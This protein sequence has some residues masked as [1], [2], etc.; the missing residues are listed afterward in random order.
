MIESYGEQV[1]LNKGDALCQL[2]SRTNMVGY[3]KTGY[4]IYT[5]EGCNRIGGFTF[6]GALFVDYPNC[7]HNLP[8]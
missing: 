7:L 3:V 2:G 8:A 4:L 5:I 6:P 1:T